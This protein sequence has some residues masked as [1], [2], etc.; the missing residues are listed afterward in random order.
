MNKLFKLIYVNIL[1]LFGLNEIITLEKKNIKSNLELKAI[2]IAIAG[3]IGGYL[4]YKMYSLLNVNSLVI[5][6]SI[7]VILCFLLNFNNINSIL[8]HDNDTEYL[9]SLP[10]STKQI[11]LSKLFNIYLKN[12]I[13]V[14]IIMVTSFL[15]YNSVIN[16][17]NED[18]GIML[19]ICSL[20]IPLVPISLVTIFLYYYNYLKINNR[21]LL[22][23]LSVII[24]TGIGM[25][26]YFVSNKMLLI[27]G[28]Y[29]YP[30]LGL[31][32]LVVK[33]Y[34]IISF[35][36]FIIISVAVV[37]LYTLIM[38]DKYNVMVST[39][40]GFNK[41]KKKYKVKSFNCKSLFGVVKKELLYLFSNHK[42]FYN[43]FSI[44]I[45]FSLALVIIVL[46]GVR[47]T[48]YE[49]IVKLFGPTI[50]AMTASFGVFTINGISLEQNN[51]EMIKAMPISFNKYMLAKVFSNLLV[52]MFF[53]LVNGI[54]Y[55]IIFERHG[56]DMVIGYILSLG[57]VLFNIVF[58]L[59]IDLRFPIKNA[60]NE[61]EILNRRLLSIVPKI[62]AIVIGLLPMLLPM[63]IDTKIILLTYL[64]LLLLGTLLIILIYL[65]KRNAIL[66]NLF[67]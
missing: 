10:I 27:I 64:G 47:I 15:Y 52:A 60:N 24:V 31:F 54:C 49:D 30:L 22:N 62:I 59:F 21:V 11:V 36:L 7:S 4:L 40:K 18:L 1:K 17:V 8:F 20:M 5:G 61:S 39:L 19:I 37:Y 14:I 66:K 44:S 16:R 46:L 28:Y 26:C 42:Y 41:S 9:F 58:C 12:I 65:I 43:T 53:I 38:S 3:L 35:I 57:A 23:V 48:N 2:I 56:F 13:Y 34:D 25:L 51:L 67:N 63:I 6:F 55:T 33:S 29:I 45:L 32:Y 50:L